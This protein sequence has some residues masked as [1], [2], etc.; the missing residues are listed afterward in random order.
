MITELYEKS[1][2]RRRCQKRKYYLTFLYDERQNRRT[3]YRSA[4]KLS[5]SRTLLLGHYSKVFFG[6][7]ID[8]LDLLRVVPLISG[9]STPDA[10]SNALLVPVVGNQWSPARRPYRMSLVFRLF[11]CEKFGSLSD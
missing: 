9:L 8:L 10:Y 1:L 11:A 2:V 7:D 5:K 3:P 6:L 4:F